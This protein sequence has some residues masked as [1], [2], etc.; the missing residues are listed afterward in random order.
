MYNTK[1]NCTYQ[2]IE[3]DNTYRSEF[4]DIFN[5]ENLEEEKLTKEFN[6]LFSVIEDCKD[7]EIKI[8]FE[9]C[10]KKVASLFLVEDL[11]TGLM[12]L[13]SYD[14]FYLMHN[15]MCE[16][17]ETETISYTNMNALKEKINSIENE[18]TEKNKL[19]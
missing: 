1:L 3:C 13:Y 11:L 9:E 16:L 18:T 12:M 19:K 7:S 17:I 10:M 14:Y 2:I 8:F 4:L 5:L 15:C 6:Y